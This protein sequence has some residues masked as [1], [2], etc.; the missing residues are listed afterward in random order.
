MKKREKMTMREK[1]AFM[2]PFTITLCTI[3][4]LYGLLKVDV[5][6]RRMSFAD[7]KPPFEV[8]EKYDGT[9]SLRIR[10]MGID[11]ERDFTRAMELWQ[12]FKD[13]CCIP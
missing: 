9:S 5:N 13:F 3:I 10:F 1:R 7:T 8:V 11:T 12:K 6:G 4:L 2:I